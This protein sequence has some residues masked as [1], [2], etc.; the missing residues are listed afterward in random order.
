MGGFGQEYYAVG[1]S[2]ILMMIEL[3]A[4]LDK[5]KFKAVRNDKLININV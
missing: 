5:A 3:V 4:L 2:K 1:K